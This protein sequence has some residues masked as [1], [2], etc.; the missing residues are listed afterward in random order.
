MDLDKITE[1]EEKIISNLAIHRLEPKLDIKPI[2][3]EMNKLIELDHERNKRALNLIIFGV[4][5]RKMRT[6]SQ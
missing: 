4:K 3:E 1:L 6:P 5:E 2:K